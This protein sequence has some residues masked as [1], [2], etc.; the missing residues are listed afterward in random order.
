MKKEWRQSITFPKYEVSNYG[1]IRRKETK[2]ELKPSYD[3]YGYLRICI[4]HK[5]AFMHRLVGEA[6][7]ENPDNKTIINHKDSIRD[8]NRVDNLEWVTNKENI[9]HGYK[10]GNV[11]PTIGSKAAEAANKK[12]VYI[13]ETN[14]RFDSVNSCA[15]HLKVRPQNISRVLNG[16]RQKIHN[17]HIKYMDGDTGE[18]KE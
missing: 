12:P 14:E 6:F 2:R 10:Y 11:D 1:D 15:E 5:N 9:I 7:I 18:I 17:L 13:V 3:K 4:N 16:E 8:N